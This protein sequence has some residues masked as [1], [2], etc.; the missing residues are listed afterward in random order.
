[1]EYNEKVMELLEKRLTRQLASYL[2]VCAHCGACSESCHYYTSIGDPD[3]VPPYKTDFLRKIYKGKYDLLGSRIPGW[4]GA[5]KHV[6]EDMLKEMVNHAYGAC[7]MCRRCTVNCPMGIDTGM[8][9]R[10]TRAILT[11]LGMTPAGLRAT[12]DVHHESGNNM[13]V[14]KEDLIDTLEW[15]EEELQED[16]NDP[17]AKIPYDK[18]GVRMI[19]T[20]NPREAK[21]SPLSIKA[22]AKIF[23][24]AGESWAIS[25]DSWDVTN[26]ALFSGEDA[27]AKKNAGELLEAARKLGAEEVIMAE[28]GHGY[29]SFRWEGEN[30]LQ[31]N[32][33]LRVRGFV[34]LIA[35]YIR[36][37]RITLDP[38]KHQELVTY[39]DPCNQARNGGVVD[40]PRYIL[41]KAVANFKEMTP[42][43]KENFCCGAG[44]GMLTMSEFKDRRLAASKTKAEQIT[45]TG[46][47]VVA[48]SCHNCLDGL[49]EGCKHYNVD[50]HIH[51]LV[52]IVADAL[53][54]P[55][56]KSPEKTTEEE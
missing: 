39:H 31:Q 21:Y 38:S 11:E 51:N 55:E 32:Y 22:A 40:E 26:Y 12:I 41:S 33:G 17:T 20:V 52:T 49:H 34:E 6:D 3:M 15:M 8:I 35:E 16:L 18:Q 7:T 5:V 37:G 27:K 29:R 14:T 1:M 54:M 23:H 46:A 9:I 42:S 2:H 56:K 48:T 45:A 13:A 4:F 43:G 25:T 47:K 28:C 53:V 30:W 50:V 36:D 19:Y 44:S 10:T 24:A